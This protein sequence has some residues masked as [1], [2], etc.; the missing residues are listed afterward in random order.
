MLF[1]RHGESTWNQEGRI[2]GWSDAPLSELGRKQAE[3]LAR[4][5]AGEPVR[6]I[7]ASPLARAA[8]TAEVIAARLRLGITLDPRLREYGLGDLEGLTG[9]EV[10]ERYPEIHSAWRESDA[11]V[12][13]P[14]E[15]GRQAFVERVW[16]AMEEI[17][18]RHPD[19]A[20]VVVAHGGTVSIFLI[21]LLGL[22]E[23]RRSPFFF[24]NASIT[25]V[26]FGSSRPRIIRLND[27]CHLA[28][29]E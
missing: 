18:R 8:E 16:E 25:E 2:Q 26:T 15:E 19:E 21:G 14:G 28:A 23:G 17:I 22:S 4:R 7:Y 13:L 20:V 3:R 29:A 10:A 11:W 9:E 6:A 5:L 27:T 12:A 1:I 24:D